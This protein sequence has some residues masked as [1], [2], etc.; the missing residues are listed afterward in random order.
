VSDTT[1]GILL[2]VI[3]VLN[4]YWAARLYTLN[5]LTGTPE[6]LA[7]VRAKSKRLQR[8]SRLSAVAVFSIAPSR[9]NF[10]SM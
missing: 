9:L 6:V 1:L 3:A 4:V 5:T 10:R 7:A 2:V 8:W